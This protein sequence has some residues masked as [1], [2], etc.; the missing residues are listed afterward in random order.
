M[1][2]V[3]V[4]SRA[5][6]LIAFSSSV[7]RWDLWFSR[8]WLGNVVWRDVTPCSLV[9]SGSHGADCEMRV[10]LNV[11]PRSTV[12][13]CQRVAGTHCLHLHSRRVGYNL[14]WSLW[15]ET[16]INSYQNTCCP[17]TEKKRINQTHPRFCDFIFQT[18]KHKFFCFALLSSPSFFLAFFPTLLLYFNHFNPRRVL[19]KRKSEGKRP[20]GRPRI[21]W[22]II[23]KSFLKK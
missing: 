4:G 6:V 8:S 12:G 18:Q 17:I 14:S 16:C 22:K 15:S 2:S 23:L 5:E 21:C 10:W 19:V 9:D 7:A 11:T 13:I 1:L 3:A 20:L